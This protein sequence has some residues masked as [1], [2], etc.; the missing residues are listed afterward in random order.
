MTYLL[1]AVLAY[2][3]GWTW[4]HSSARIRIVNVGATAEQD[5]AALDAAGAAEHRAQHDSGPAA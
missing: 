5:Q 3:L 4:G 2:A 1:V